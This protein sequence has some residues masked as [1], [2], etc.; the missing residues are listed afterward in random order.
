MTGK[1]QQKRHRNLGELTAHHHVIKMKDLIVKINT[2]GTDAMMLTGVAEGSDGVAGSASRRM[3][4][5]G[6]G[7]DDEDLA[8]IQPSSGGAEIRTETNAT[9]T[10]SGS[11]WPDL[12]V[13]DPDH[14]M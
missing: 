4:Y 2:E 5:N 11:F 3:S 14:P 12:E 9:D 13:L 7:D 6:D 1:L 8:L 10:S